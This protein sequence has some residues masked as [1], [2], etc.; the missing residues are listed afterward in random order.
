MWRMS[1][2]KKKESRKTQKFLTRAQE[3][4]GCHSLRWKRALGG[5]ALVGSRGSAF[6]SY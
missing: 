4:F 3:W 2:R 1:E 5:R 6:G